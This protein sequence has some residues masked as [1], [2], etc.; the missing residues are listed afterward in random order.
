MIKIRPQRLQQS[1]NRSLAW[2]VAVLSLLAWG[3]LMQALHLYLLSPAAWASQASAFPGFELLESAWSALWPLLV[4]WAFLM[5]VL[6]DAPAHLSGSAPQALSAWTILIPLAVL[7]FLLSVVELM[8]LRSAFGRWRMQEAR[9]EP[10]HVPDPAPALEP[11]PT[12][13]PSPMLDAP[14]PRL[15]ASPSSP[16]LF[17]AMDQVEGQLADL[18]SELEA[19]RVAIL[20]ASL[21]QAL[22]EAD[23]PLEQARQ[24]CDRLRDLARG[25][26]AQQQIV[27]ARAMGFRA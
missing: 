19:L 26:R 13:V 23:E 9:E 2:S 10:V 20:N 24:G 8:G 4:D 22:D 14:R 5:Q 6:V 7:G 16:E 3:L 18:Q 21:P 11:V 27:Q 15:E 25:I 1:L 17:D 12:P